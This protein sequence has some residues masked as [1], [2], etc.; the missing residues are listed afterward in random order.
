MPAEPKEPGCGLFATSRAV[1]LKYVDAARLI[2]ERLGAVT[3]ILEQLGATARGR[4]GRSS[5]H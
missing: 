1:I 5:S 2:R 4:P 3:P